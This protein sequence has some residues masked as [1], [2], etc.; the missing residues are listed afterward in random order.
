MLFQIPVRIGTSTLSAL[1]Q[2]LM[3]PS[4]SNINWQG[5]DF[6][7]FKTFCNFIELSSKMPKPTASSE[8]HLCTDFILEPAVKVS[9]HW[10]SEGDTDY[11]LLAEVALFLHLL[12]LNRKRWQLHWSSSKLSAK[13]KEEHNLNRTWIC[14]GSRTRALLQTGILS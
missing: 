10:L 4:R 6:I 8:G 7:F 3:G 1:S 14:K 9:Q 12:A 2:L 11:H 13:C 5:S